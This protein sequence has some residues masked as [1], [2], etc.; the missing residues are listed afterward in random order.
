MIGAPYEGM[1]SRCCSKEEQ[2]YCD[3]GFDSGIHEAKMNQCPG[4]D[5]ACAQRSTFGCRLK[6]VINIRKP[7]QSDAA[8]QVE[9]YSNGYKYS[10]YHFF[11]LV[12]SHLNI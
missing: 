12:F 5:A 6:S 9:E 2:R 7:D 11:R 8:K 3:E 10:A 1:G 4:Q